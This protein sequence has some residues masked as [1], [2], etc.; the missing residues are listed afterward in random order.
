[1]NY[2]YCFITQDDMVTWQNLGKA[3]SYKGRLGRLIVL[4]WKE[5]FTKINAYYY[6]IHNDYLRHA[7]DLKYNNVLTPLNISL[8]GNTANKELIFTAEYQQQQKVW[9]FVYLSPPFSPG[10]CAC[11]QYVGIYKNAFDSDLSI[12]LWNL[13]HE[14]MNDK[15]TTQRKIFCK[16]LC[17]S[18][19]A[20]YISQTKLTNTVI[21]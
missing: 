12:N 3:L 6:N 10:C 8:S 20:G 15:I 9:I 7:P 14:K 16:V 17:V 18:V 1:M 21:I 19:K 11:R 5:M 4:S 2:V 13:Y